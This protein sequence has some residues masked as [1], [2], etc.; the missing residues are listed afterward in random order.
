M[1]IAIYSYVYSLHYPVMNL[2]FYQTLPIKCWH[3][4]FSSDT[5]S[6]HLRKETSIFSNPDTDH[7]ANKHKQHLLQKR[8]RITVN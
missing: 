4:V 7:Q 3:L 6:R 2:C 5:R 1:S 8:L